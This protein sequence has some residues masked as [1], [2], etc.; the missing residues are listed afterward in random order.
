MVQ[1]ISWTNDEFSSEGDF[2]GSPGIILKKKTVWK[3]HFK[4]WKTLPMGQGVITYCHS[5][6]SLEQPANITADC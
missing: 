2:W 3:L 4:I 5:D 6:D 1:F